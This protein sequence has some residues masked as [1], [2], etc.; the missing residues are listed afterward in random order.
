MPINEVNDSTEEK[1][2]YVM[3]INGNFGSMNVNPYKKQLDKM[4]SINSEAGKK[5]DKLEISSEAKQL[6]NG[7]RFE[8][9]RQEK[10][11]SLKQQ[12]ESG[13]YQ[14]DPKKVAQK[15]YEFWTKQ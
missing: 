7:S 2:V 6:L 11:E 13:T 8:A 15:M 5:A 10:I 12:I 1:E 9:E 14:V 3:K 4:K